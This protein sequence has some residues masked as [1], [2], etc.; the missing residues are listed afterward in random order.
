[1]K[2]KNVFIA[3]FVILIVIVLGITMYSI[4]MNRMKNNKPVIFSNWG[5][6]YVPPIDIDSDK[7]ENAIQNCI[8]SMN[9]KSP[10][11]DNE[12]QFMAMEIFLIEEKTEKNLNVYAWI[13]EESY[14]KQGEELLVS[15]GSSIPYK[16]EISKEDNSYEVSNYRIPRDGSYY[17]EDMKDMF[18]T[19]VYNK[20]SKVHSDGTI[21]KLKDSIKK[22][23]NEYFNTNNNEN[24]PSFFGK[25]IES[26][27]NYIIV[28]PYEDEDIRKSAD[29]ISIGLGEY[30]DAIYMVGT[31]IKVT[32]TGTILETYPAKIEAL[33]I[34]I[35]SVDD[36]SI[37][38]EQRKDLG[39]KTIVSKDEI[40]DYTYSIFSMGGN[41]NIQIKDQLYTLRDALLNNKITIEEILQKA[42]KDL[43]SDIIKGGMYKDGGSMEYQYNDYTIVKFNN[44]NG[45]RDL[46]I[47]PAGKTLNDIK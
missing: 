14:Y 28:E 18:P 1:M 17:T 23:V 26:A 11:Y 43:D 7:I 36:F 40:K 10:R 2:K 6:S 27:A 29:K 44:L 3:L 47:I 8:L 32:Y 15:T 16:F 12:K 31:N 9:S 35:K 25:V 24:N 22:Q 30:N 42:N 46:Y 5:Y 20:I 45:R 4:D 19:D 33:N 41:V 38:F 37:G 13:L 39:I 21:E 34:E